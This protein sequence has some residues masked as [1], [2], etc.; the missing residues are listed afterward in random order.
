MSHPILHLDRPGVGGER[1]GGGEEEK[2]KEDICMVNKTRQWRGITILTL[3]ILTTLL[4]IN[5]RRQGEREW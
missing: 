2:G 3:Q 1:G 4:R 5:C